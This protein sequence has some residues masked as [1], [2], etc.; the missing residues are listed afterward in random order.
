[1]K[2]SEVLKNLRAER[3]AK[4]KEIESIQSKASDAGR[5]KDAEEQ[6]KFDTLMSEIDAINKEIA[7]NQKLEKM[8]T[9]AAQSVNVEVDD[10]GDEELDLDDPT[11]VTGKKVGAKVN[12]GNGNEGVRGVRTVHVTKKLDKGIALA[13]YVKCV[14]AS[15]GDMTQAI[16]FA[17]LHY[18][19]MPQLNEILKSGLINGFLG[20]VMKTAVAGGTPTDAAYGGPLMAYTQYA[21]DF[22]EFLRP[23]TIIGKFGQN[24]IPALRQIPFNIHIR[25]QTTGGTSGWVGAGKSKP[26]TA[27]GFN[28][29][30]LGF[31]KI[32]CIAVLTEELLRFSD[33]S[34]DILVRDALAGAVIERMDVDF[35][36]PNKAAV[37]N[38]SPA[39]I[40]HGSTVIHT[41]GT[42]A[43]HVRD[44]IGAVMRGM[45]KANLRLNAPVFIMSATLAL[46]LSLLRN[47]FGQPEFP[48]ININGGTLEGVPV[49][50]SEYVS[51]G[52]DTA[53]EMVILVNASDI[54][55]ADDGTVTIDASREA[56]IQMDTAPTQDATVGTGTTSVSM[57]QTDSV[58]LRAERYVN[59]A[60]RRNQA[61]A[62]IDNAVWTGG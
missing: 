21:A 12:K 43:Q 28:D 52:T 3:A 56:S 15:R 24:G 40:T 45:L 19:D 25:G 17:K 16:G 33:P 5:N 36:D 59:W 39:S 46:Q 32:A 1:M 23:A 35:I 10:D 38:V 60:K 8:Q 54:Y 41:S 9:Q 55:L 4:L 6:D 29:V 57:F 47:A 20:D 42:T 11:T 50:T 2:I 48:T 30:Y 49:I 53:G 7:D 26:V 61:V 27:F 18:P 31:S 13:R 14:G 44:D 22:I 51:R 34:A 58:A 37:A 62:Y